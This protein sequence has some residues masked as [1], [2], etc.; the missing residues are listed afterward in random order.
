MKKVLFFIYG[1]I[2]YSAFLAVFLYA[3]GF[4]ENFLVPKSIDSG[5]GGPILPALFINLLLLGL[6]AI[7]HSVMARPGFKKWWTRIVPKPIE[8]STYVLL[9]SAVLALLFW[10]WRPM[11]DVVW[12]VASEP[13][14]ILLWTVCGL[15]WMIVLVSTFMISHSHLF[16]LMQVQKHLQNQPQPSLKFETPGLYRYI[17]HPIM[18]GFLIAFWATPHMTVGHL[19]F[20]IATTGYI[21]VALR[22]EERDLIQFFGDKYR[23]YRRRVR[24]FIPIPKETDSVA[25]SWRLERESP[26]PKYDVTKAAGQKDRTETMER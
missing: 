19:L 14:R 21:L 25:P 12:S 22:F 8:R 11:P 20:A 4:V 17:R 5:V 6:F 13:V 23:D 7:Q 10:Q 2:S 9:A 16:G 24:M 3:I 1:I 26:E 18:V 15:G